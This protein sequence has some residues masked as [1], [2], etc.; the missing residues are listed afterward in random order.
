M[1]Y[2]H[3]GDFETSL[4][5]TEEYIEKRKTRSGKVY[6]VSRS[7]YFADNVINVKAILIYVTYQQSGFYCKIRK[8][9]FRN[10]QK[11]R[12]HHWL[13]A[14]VVLYPKLGVGVGSGEEGEKGQFGFR[15]AIDALCSKTESIMNGREVFVEHI[16]GFS[17]L[18]KRRRIHFYLTP[19]GQ[20]VVCVSTLIVMYLIDPSRALAETFYGYRR[21]IRCRTTVTGSRIRQH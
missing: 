15:K 20:F 7:Q 14:T 2:W 12:R 13:I 5:S 6:F 19:V 17:Q 8:S 10:H 4:R 21:V 18:N 1:R 11:I 3:G 16:I 9:E